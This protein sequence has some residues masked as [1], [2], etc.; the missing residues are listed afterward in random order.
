[1]PSAK[2]HTDRNTDD[3]VYAAALDATAQTGAENPEALAEELIRKH[4]AMVHEIKDLKQRLFEKTCELAEVKSRADI[5]EVDPA[6]ISDWF[7]N[8][9]GENSLPISETAEL[10]NFRAL[11]PSSIVRLARSSKLS[12]MP[13]REARRKAPWKIGAWRALKRYHRRIQ[14]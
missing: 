7:K 4:D 9:H 14:N 8:G 3:P 10:Q 5:R 11:S 6:Q 2:L 1:M 12:K 13:W